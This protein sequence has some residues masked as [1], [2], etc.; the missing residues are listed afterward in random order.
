MNT[1]RKIVR[2]PVIDA[3][4]REL[5]FLKQLTDKGGGGER[6]MAS[7]LV[8][9]LLFLTLASNRE[10]AKILRA[11]RK[12]LGLDEF[13]PNDLYDQWV[14]RRVHAK[15]VPGHIA[16]RKKRAD[17]REQI[18]DLT[19]KEYKGVREQLSKALGNVE[20]ITVRVYA[21]DVLK[22]QS[23]GKPKHQLLAVTYHL[24]RQ[25]VHI[26][27]L[28]ITKSYLDRDNEKKRADH[29][30][31]V[32]QGQWQMLTER[33]REHAETEGTPKESI[34]LIHAPTNSKL[35]NLLTISRVYAVEDMPA[36][37][38]GAIE[39]RYLSKYSKQ[40]PLRQVS[41]APILRKPSIDEWL[42]DI[43]M[44]AL[45]PLVDLTHR[46]KD[47]LIST[48]WKKISMLRQQKP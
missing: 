24:Q 18:V 37:P 34:L 11:Y 35:S 5:F 41:F 7:L 36:L 48:L 30:R 39:I 40:T 14:N 25:W 13:L 6:Q 9:E 43:D 22:P 26:Q 16:D 4:N 29:A 45:P 33:I 12:T 8:Q 23:K 42:A 19:R 17:F 32:S 38:T 27:T 3:Q 1:I 10:L 21:V 15:G 44:P 47:L 2:K 31:M 20:H 28:D 46:Q